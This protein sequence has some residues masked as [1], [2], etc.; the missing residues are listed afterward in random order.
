MTTI[1]LNVTA[2]QIDR[3]V[4]NANKFLEE[5]GPPSDF[6]TPA[7]IS[8]ILAQKVG[9]SYACNIKPSDLIDVSSFTNIQYVDWE[10]PDSS[11]DGSTWATA[12]RNIGT[13]INNAIA[14]G[15]PTRIKIRGGIYSR[16]Q[17]IGNSGSPLSLTAPITLEAVNGRVVTGSFDFLS[18]TQNA[19][20]TNVYEASRSNT[21]DVLNPSIQDVYGNHVR[22]KFVSSALECSNNPGSFYTDNTTLYVNT[23]QGVP[24]TD[25]N[26]WPILRA[27]NA[28]LQGN[29]DVYLYGIDFIGGSNGCLKIS[30]GS[31]NKVVADDCSFKYA[32]SGNY[33]DGLTPRDGCQILGCGLFAAFNCNGSE[34]S[35]DGFNIHHQVSVKPASL[36]VN[37][38]GY[39]NGVYHQISQSCNGYTVHDGCVGV[40]IG[41]RWLG[42][43]GTNSGHINDNTEIWSF[44]VTAGASDGDYFGGGSIGFGAF[45]VWSGNAKIWL[46]N[47]TDLGSN[48]GIYSDVQGNA[49]FRNHNGTGTKVRAVEFTR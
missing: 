22:Y 17:S 5:Y 43:L 46:E 35:K 24:P 48:I 31:T 23:H 6:S 9:D 29:Q 42:S 49:K 39:N 2:A 13:A 12:E 32:I 15:L 47:C 45:G 18:W 21:C 3:S 28:D 19:T 25:E 41:S 40:D 16:F 37:S 8:N 7:M 34:N 44:G 38:E 14:S 27:I 36:I 33:A 20:Y 4:S 11:G 30:N 26:C 10:R 1:S